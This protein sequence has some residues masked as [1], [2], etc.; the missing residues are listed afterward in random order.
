[1]R[2]RRVMPHIWFTLFGGL[3]MLCLLAVDAQ[4][5]PVTINIADPLRSNLVSGSYFFQGTLTNNT[6]SALQ[7]TLATQ[8]ASRGAGSVTFTN[9]LPL[10]TTLAPFQS[11]TVTLFR[12]DID[13]STPGSQGNMPFLQGSYSVFSGNLQTGFQLLGQASFAAS[14]GTAA[15][16]EPAT[17]VLLATGLAGVGGAATR[18][19]RRKGRA[20]D[21]ES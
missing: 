11:L 8:G 15:I 21:R 9:L 2:T 14:T 1:M 5:D 18:R 19:R 3:T 6:S 13:T 10:P 17:L 16:P 20:E 4:A 12:I 7:I